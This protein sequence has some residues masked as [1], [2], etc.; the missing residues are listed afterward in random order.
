MVSHCIFSGNVL[1]HIILFAI[2]GEAAGRR[3]VKM[4]KKAR[5]FVIFFE[6]KN[7]VKAPFEFL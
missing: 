1:V 5:I 3:K 6:I 4:R 2:T 7:T